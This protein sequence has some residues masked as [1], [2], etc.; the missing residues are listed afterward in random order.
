MNVYDNVVGYVIS[1]STGNIKKMHANHDLVTGHHKNSN[2]FWVFFMLS[3][4]HV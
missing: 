4:F 3:P 1:N 2:N